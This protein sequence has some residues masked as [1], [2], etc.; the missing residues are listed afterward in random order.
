M[1]ERK[2]E[3]EFVPGLELTRSFYE[4]VVGPLLAEALPSLRH[5]AARLD[6]GSDVLG[7]DTARSMDHDWGPRFTL[8][9]DDADLDGGA[10]A[11]DALLRRRLPRTWRGVGTTYVRKPDG[12]YFCEGDGE[13]EHGVTITTVR[14][15]LA[16]YLALDHEG[17]P[18]TAEWLCLPQQRLK[19]V[20]EGAV[21]HDGL[22]TLA[23]MRSNL[24]WYP[25]DLWRHVLACQWQRIGQ[26]APFLGRCG[27]T[28][29]ELGRR[30]VT[31]RQVRDVMRLCYYQE[32]VYPP[33]LKWFGSGFQR[34]AAAT[35]LG[36]HLATAL[37]VTTWQAA[38]VALG[39]AFVRVIERHN[40]LGLCRP[41]AAATVPF[42]GRPYRVPPA[43]VLA[44]D[45][46]EAVTDEAVRALPPCIGTLDQVADTT[47]LLDAPRRCQELRS[48]YEPR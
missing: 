35:E 42:Y 22:G 16:E 21:F 13:V 43:D 7:F 47:D 24:A 12:G 17:P 25:D 19:T 31:A 3:P 44:R 6:G 37:E 40:A 26:E 28:G 29:D 11:V 1:N 23:E 14:R 48:L 41:R 45:L 33:Y 2:P 36:G 10:P 15:F 27:E 32:R 30:L 46:K 18:T 8:F 34:L 5:S 39:A 9:L 20:V 38:E 4:G